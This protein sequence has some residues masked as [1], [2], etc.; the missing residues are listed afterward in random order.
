MVALPSGKAK[1]ENWN[2]VGSSR[3]IKDGMITDEIFV[4][5]TT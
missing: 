1:K 5:L 2:R 3:R 4:G